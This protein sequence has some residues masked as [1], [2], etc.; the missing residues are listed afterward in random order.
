MLGVHDGLTLCVPFSLLVAPFRHFIQTSSG[1]ALSSPAVLTSGQYHLTVATFHKRN[2][3]TNSF[4][5][6]QQFLIKLDLRA[7]A[8]DAFSSPMSLILPRRMIQSHLKSKQGDGTVA[9]DAPA[10]TA[11]EPHDAPSVPP[12]DP[13]TH[14]YLEV[15]VHLASSE[16]IVQACPECCHKVTRSLFCFVAWN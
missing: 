7:A 8:A 14:F 9:T 10:G 4:R 1:P 2:Q 15:T 12:G 11:P 5:T 6:G 3:D 16:A 13:E